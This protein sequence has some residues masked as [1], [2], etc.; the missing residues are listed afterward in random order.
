MQN[1][2]LQNLIE[3]AAATVNM[4]NPEDKMEIEKLQEIFDEIKQ[5][6]D[7]I[8]DV[9][10]DLVD[11]LKKTTD[12]IDIIESIDETSKTVIQLQGLIEKIC[13]SDSEENSTPA[14]QE[15]TI[16]PDDVPLVLDFIAESNEHIEAAEAG[17]LELENNPEDENTLNLI[18]RSFHTMKGMAGF[19]NLNEIGSLAHSAENLL[20]MARKAE[21]LLTDTRTDVIF[22][23]LDMLK[24]MMM[25]LET[26]AQKG[27]PVPSQQNLNQLLEKLKTFTD[28]QQAQT[29]PISKSNTV[30]DINKEKTPCQPQSEQSEKVRKTVSDEKIKVA[31]DKLDDLINMAGELVIAQLMVAEQASQPSDS[32]YELNR[33][34]AHQGKIVRKLQELS[35]SMRM[36]PIAGVFQKMS[37]LVRDLSHKSEKDV[38]LET[39]GE[40][41][42][43]DRNIV[44]KIADPLVHMIRNSVDHGI[45]SPEARSKSG[46]N[47]VG[48]IN[49]RAFH[50]AGNIVIEIQDD[51]KGLDKDQILNK[52]IDKGIVDP[53]QQLTDEQIYKLIFN[54]GLSTAQKVT[55]VSGRGVGMDV[56]K[57][58]IESLRG[59]I[60]IISEIGKGTTFTIRLP[61]T[62]ATIDGQIVTVDDNRYIV[63]INSIIAT[64]RPR[65]EQISTINERSEVVTVRGEILSLIRLN[66][67]FNIN[68]K[69][70]DPTESLLIIV[71]DEGKR[72]CIMVDQLLN[73]QQVVIK[74]LGDAIGKVNGV[75]G[76]AIMGNGTVSLIL[77]IPGIIKMSQQ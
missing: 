40:D 54:A 51:G 65:A 33:K 2:E 17:L 11:Q 16:D 66:K 20:D 38:K 23:S 56:V 32:Q 5:N 55:D 59:K 63:P 39:F 74:S 19:L 26:A 21:I 10:V 47:Q 60:D 61:L 44:D 41:T 28:P 4:V 8:K 3:K 18:F 43:L 77:D 9:P 6:I 15:N 7:N 52:A 42:E 25:E 37:R 46:K 35:M 50:Q 72:S 13:S 34:I 62:L 53:A 45:E 24:N 58:N 75:A 12:K 69:D 64:F 57:K 49:L 22:E 1:Q 73:Q 68:D 29:T 27:L 30:N 71:E 76:S 36:V 48:T 67:L 70:I 14:L 31:T